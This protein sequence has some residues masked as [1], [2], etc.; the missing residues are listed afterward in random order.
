M[1]LENLELYNEEN[2]SFEKMNLAKK[3]IDCFTYKDKD[4][5]LKPNKK[6]VYEVNMK[7][8]FAVL[9]N[10]NFFEAFNNRKYRFKV[11]FALD[12]Y[13]N[14]GESNILITDWIYKN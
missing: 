2:Q 10:G 6:Y 14:C 4:I 8:D 12:S 13:S 11:S 9:Q 7:S 3:D 1:R 5:K